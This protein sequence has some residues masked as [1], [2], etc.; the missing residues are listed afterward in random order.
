MLSK[1]QV[2]KAIQDF[3]S[4]NIN[5]HDVNA[6]YHFPNPD[7]FRVV[8]IYDKI[9][10]YEAGMEEEMTCLHIFSQEDGFPICNAFCVASE[11]GKIKLPSQWNEDYRNDVQVWKKESGKK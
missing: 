3:L 5:D 10:F 11:W 8:I 9:K 7:E 1:I 2:E 4:H 6:I